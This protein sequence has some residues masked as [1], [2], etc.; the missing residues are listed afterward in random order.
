MKKLRT[1]A[2][3]FGVMITSVALF[4]GSVSAQATCV[5]VYHQPKVPQSMEKFKK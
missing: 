2:L 3:R 5:A 4:M 1:L